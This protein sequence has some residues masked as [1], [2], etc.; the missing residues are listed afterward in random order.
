MPRMHEISNDNFV[1]L[2]S[3]QPAAQAYAVISRLTP[4]AIIVRQPQPASAPHYLLFRPQE[5]LIRLASVAATA[6]LLD[7]LE[8]ATAE[9]TPLLDADADVNSA[10]PRCIII[11]DEQPIG[12]YDAAL[13][14]FLDPQRYGKPAV[15]ATQ[16]PSSR[17]LKAE[18]PKQIAVGQ[19]VSLLISLAYQLDEQPAIAINLAPGSLLTVI[20]QAQ[21]GLV[22]L[23]PSEAQLLVD[24]EEESAPLRFELRAVLPGLGKVRVLCFYANQLL[25]TIDLAPQITAL[26]A[27][28]NE[29]PS[30]QRSYLA[31]IQSKQPDLQLLILEDH[32]QG[33]LTLR[34]HASTADPALG[35]N[36]ESF[37]PVRLPA[38][39]PPYLQ[40]LFADLQHLPT[41]SSS[42]RLLARQ[43]I[44]RRGADLFA[45]LFP[46]DLR[47]RLWTLRPAIHSI[48]ILSNEPWLP[49]EIVRFY[50]EEH[51]EISEGPFLAEA[52]QC[53]RWFIGVPRRLHLALRRLAVIAPD[54]AGLPYAPAERAFLL[55]LADSQRSI[56]AL[57]ASYIELIA[58]LSQRAY[59]GLHFIGHGHFNPADPY[60]AAIQLAQGQQLSPADIS[61]RATNCCREQPLVFLNACQTSQTG[62]ALTGAGGWAERFIK[63][64]A[65][66]FVGSLWAIDD[67]AAHAFTQSFYSQVLAGVPLGIAAHT[68]RAAIR[69]MDELTWLAYTIF[70]DPFATT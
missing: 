33:A 59:D 3:D 66:A 45:L 41:R 69:H 61:G 44:E 28:A 52:F 15:L 22:L 51:D 63:N 1:L 46:A 40:S 50:A 56:T 25:G 64:G 30:T 57:Q 35:L 34:L 49:W 26:A 36:F 29:R 17:V 11:A 62:L 24:T 5:L 13:P 6:T 9:P 4:E 58:A 8:L 31:A 18:L 2:H 32:E 68:A 37:G 42:E 21:R 7:S 47:A 12:F 55:G 67:A 60:R 20:V 43:Q 48:H 23:G 70:A 16:P 54:D 65:A 27:P 38:Q 10:P 14:F 39:L 19:S 53:T